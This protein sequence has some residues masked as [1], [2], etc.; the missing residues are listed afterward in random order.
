MTEKEQFLEDCYR[1][2]YPFLLHLCRREVSGSVLYVDIIDTCIQDTF[3]LAY[4]AYGEIKDYAYLRAWLVR[5]CM[6]RL[7]PYVKLQRQR[8]EHE[9]FSLDDEQMQGDTYLPQRSAEMQADAAE[10]LQTLWD[11]LA[12]REKM[13]FHC[14]FIEGHS[15]EETA[16]LAHCSPATVRA[17]VFRIRKKAKK[18]SEAVNKTDV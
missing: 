14:R 15:P 11:S 8:Q 1:Q 5:T 10:S 12:P 4:R 18:I 13:I 17:T 2:Y 9:A 16:E 7:I 6:H 3:L